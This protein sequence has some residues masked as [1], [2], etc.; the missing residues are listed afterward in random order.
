MK[1][2]V[3]KLRQLKHSAKLFLKRFWLGRA[4][5][6]ILGAIATV[7]SVILNGQVWESDD[8]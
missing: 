7:L 3:Q 6:A 8:A 5:L 4:L 2:F 1:A